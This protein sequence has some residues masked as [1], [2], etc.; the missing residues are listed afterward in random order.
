MIK[1]LHT[2]DIDLGALPSFTNDFSDTH[3]QHRLAT[4]NA[5]IDLALERQVDLFVVLDHLFF[6]AIP[7]SEWLDAVQAGLLQLEEQ[8]I[9]VLLYR[10]HTDE[11]GEQA[12]DGLERYYVSHNGTAPITLAIGAETVNLHLLHL[13]LSRETTPSSAIPCES[14]VS[15]HIGILLMAVSGTN[16]SNPHYDFLIHHKESIQA[17]NHHYVA[18]GYRHASELV[19]DGNVLALCPG[20]PQAIDFSEK[21]PRHCALVILDQ[22]RVEVEKI[23]IQ[24][25]LFDQVCIDISECCDERDICAAVVALAQEDLVV[26]VELVGQIEYPLTPSRIVSQCHNMFTYLDIVDHTSL[27]NSRYLKSMAK[28][29][30][31]RGKLAQAF[32]TMNTSTN[33]VDQRRIYELAL[34]DLL[35]RF[36][37]VQ[38]ENSGAEL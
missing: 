7:D 26:Q 27:I 13:P 29:N 3:H 21:G 38:A 16:C 18:V 35:H 6:G 22:Q 30:T 20:S 25:S 10:G 12:I 14:L 17:L 33:D 24:Q 19:D 1:I 5:L 32:I 23:E 15:Y 9:T 36:N 4:F 11:G 28:E 37:A 31:V 8:G 2:S 34:R